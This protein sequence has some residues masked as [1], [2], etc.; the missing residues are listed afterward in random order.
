MDCCARIPISL[1]ELPT[2][3]ITD[4]TIPE[5]GPNIVSELHLPLAAEKGLANKTDLQKT[6]GLPENPDVPSYL[7]HASR[8]AEGD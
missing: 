1:S 6:A 3:S 5:N 4:R 8:T 7:C 2:E